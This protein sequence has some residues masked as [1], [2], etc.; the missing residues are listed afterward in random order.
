MRTIAGSSLV[1]FTIFPLA[2]IF[3]QLRSNSTLRCNRSPSLSL[4]ILYTRG[5]ECVYVAL[6]K[7]KPHF[8]ADY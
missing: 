4:F 6:K 7:I 3:L 5:P 2:R 8:A 1:D